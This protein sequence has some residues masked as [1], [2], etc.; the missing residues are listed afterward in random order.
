MNARDVDGPDGGLID[1][2]YRQKIEAY[3]RRH[4]DLSR[5]EAE[6]Q[7]LLYCRRAAERFEGEP[8][9][10][11]LRQVAWRLMTNGPGTADRYARA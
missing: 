10:P 6:Q 4:P 9:K 11:L 5:C 3:A 1:A 7:F 8:T 2:K